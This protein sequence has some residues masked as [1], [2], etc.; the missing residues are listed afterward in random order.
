MFRK[1]IGRLY[2]F[3]ARWRA[4]K[5]VPAL[6][7]Y[8]VIAAPHTTNWDLPLTLAIGWVQG[9][10]FR[11]IGKKSLFRFPYGWFMRFLGGVPVDRSVRTHFVDQVV[12]RFDSEEKFVLV[13]P[14][15][16][17]RSG[18]DYWKSGFYHMAKGAGVPI[19]LGYLDYSRRR[20]G[21]GPQIE[22][23]GDVAAD[24]EQVR[25]FYKK[26]M[27]RF[28]ELFTSPRLQEEE[29]SGDPE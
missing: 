8:V 24:M 23:S 6:P 10:K 18:G 25:G 1:V 17:T 5:N 4:E 15:E 7:K 14:A 28:P 3:F 20:G 11:W 19:V 12:Q 22:P 27:A 2:L 29:T 26:E 9:L 21:L 13:I 16:G